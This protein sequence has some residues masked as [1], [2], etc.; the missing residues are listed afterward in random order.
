MNR[1]Y[2]KGMKPCPLC[3][4]PMWNRS[5]L[6]KGCNKGQNHYAWRGD[7]ARPETKRARVENSA[8][9]L[10]GCE[11]SGCDKAATDRHHI[12]GNTGNNA[13]VNIQFL[14][15][16]HHMQIDG[17]ADRLR[18][19]AREN[20]LKAVKPPAPCVNCGRLAKP[21]SK[22]RCHACYNYL[23]RKGFDNPERVAA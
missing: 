13:R 19:I 16:A 21:L 20:S 5:K 8:R 10:G 22:G 15:R 3:D 2:P 6:C 18:E 14:C 17:R 7:A 9:P 23:W 1:T 12:D 4:E 11:F